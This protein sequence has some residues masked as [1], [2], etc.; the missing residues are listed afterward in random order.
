M[1]TIPSS[2]PQQEAFTETPFPCLNSHPTTP[3]DRQRQDIRNS[4]YRSMEMISTP[5]HLD[6]PFVKHM[7][8]VAMPYGPFERAH[9]FHRQ[10][11]LSLMTI[12]AIENPER[13]PFLY[14]D[15]TPSHR[16][17]LFIPVRA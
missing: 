3:A 15:S 17:P 7:V 9:P 12:C 11:S 10:T 16:R 5:S 2:S 6:P 1:E 4:S 8:V 13:I 14:F